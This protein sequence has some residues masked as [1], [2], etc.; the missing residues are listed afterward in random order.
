MRFF[1]RIYLIIRLFSYCTRFGLWR[2]LWRKKIL[3]TFLYSPLSYLV[4]RYAAKLN[5]GERLCSTFIALGGSFVKFGQ[6]LSIRP[7]IIGNEL[8]DALRLLQDKIPPFSAKKARKIITDNLNIPIDDVFTHFKDTPYAAASIAQVHYAILQNGQEVAVKILHPN[9][10]KLFARDIDL[11]LMLTRNLE[12]FL[13]RTRLFKLYEIVETY[14]SWVQSELN[15]RFEATSCAELGDN[16]KDDPNITIPNI[17][18]EYSTQNILVTDWIA[19]IKIDEK[20]KLLVAGHNPQQIITLAVELFF[21]QV[22]RDGFFHADIHP[23]NLFVQ[24]DGSLAA[25]DFG[26]VGRLDKKT[27]FF[28]A[29]ILIGFIYHDYDLVAQTYFDMG[30]VPQHQSKREFSLALRKIGEPLFVDGIKTISFAEILIS[31]IT[32]AHRFD[33]QPRLDLLLLHKTMVQAEGIGR[34]LVPKQNIWLL[35][36]PLIEEWLLLNRNP[37]AQLKSFTQEILPLIVKLPRII[38]QFSD[39]VGNSLENP[40][41][42]S[43]NNS[44]AT[45]TTLNSVSTNSTYISRNKNIFRPILIFFCG[46]IAGMSLIAPEIF[47]DTLWLQTWLENNFLFQKKLT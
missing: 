30:Y 43:L 29:D 14:Q 1:T 11:F 41:N 26:I 16:L 24:K 5:D 42:N 37:L 36:Q 32:L 34:I 47:F 10:T 12:R 31:M 28:L 23:G 35:S 20:Q 27:R 3:P 22:F 7:D 44:L 18:W 19:G 21:L 2:L 33:M 25:V 9:I 4:S 38:A 8:A 46:L 39:S 6:I 17:H 45:S 15:L 40:L 13:P